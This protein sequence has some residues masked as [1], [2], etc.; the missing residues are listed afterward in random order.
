MDLTL[1]FWNLHIFQF[2]IFYN[3]PLGISFFFFQRGHRNSHHAY[4]PCHHSLLHIASL[5]RVICDVRHLELAC[6]NPLLDIASLL[7]G[8]CNAPH[9]ELACHNPL[10]DIASLLHGRCN[11]HHFELPC[12][13]PLLDIA[14]FA[15]SIQVDVTRYVQEKQTA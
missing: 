9:F 6:H 10:L 14:F 12:H 5:L 2:R 1:V 8:L 3:P 13:N 7:H 4:I 15:A 11:V